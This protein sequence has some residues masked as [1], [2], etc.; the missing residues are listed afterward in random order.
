M[1]AEANVFRAATNITQSLYNMQCVFFLTVDAIGV[2]WDF[3]RQSYFDIR[4][5]FTG[6]VGGLS[7]MT[8]AGCVIN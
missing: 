4:R 2:T 3:C 6:I 1:F 5:H 8:F 7:L